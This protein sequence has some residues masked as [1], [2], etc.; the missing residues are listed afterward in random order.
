MMNVLSSP[1]ESMVIVA[2][3]TLSR[4]SAALANVRYAIQVANALFHPEFGVATLGVFSEL[5][6][7]GVDPS[8]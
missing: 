2:R 6:R 3:I 5:E 8:R 7:E 1:D 4:L